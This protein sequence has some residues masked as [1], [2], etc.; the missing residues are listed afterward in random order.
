MKDLRQL[1]NRISVPV[2]PDEDG[3]TG[4]QCPNAECEGYFG[5]LTG[6]L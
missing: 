2:T 5:D 1:E 3:F 6:G 4:R